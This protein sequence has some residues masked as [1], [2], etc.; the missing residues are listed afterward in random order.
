MKTSELKGAKLAY[1]VAKAEGECPI[2]SIVD[3][4][5]HIRWSTDRVPCQS[6]PGTVYEPHEDWLQGGPIIERELISIENQQRYRSDGQDW[7]AEHGTAL[8]N[9]KFGATA[10]GQT[11]LVAAMRAYVASRFGDTVPDEVAP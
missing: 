4:K 10:Y 1:W 3:G 5:C 2:I 7:T 6:N 9:S 8:K 11:A